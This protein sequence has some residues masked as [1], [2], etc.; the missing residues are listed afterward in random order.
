VPLLIGLCSAVQI[1]P[2]LLI[3]LVKRSWP[4]FQERNVSVLILG[5]V[6][7]FLT[8]TTSPAASNPVL[9]GIPLDAFAVQS[10]SQLWGHWLPFVAGYALW[11]TALLVRVRNLVIQHLRGGF[12][13]SGLLQML[14]AW[15]PWAA[16]SMLPVPVDLYA[17]IGLLVILGG[18]F[19]MLSLQL[20]PLRRDLDDLLPSM[21]LGICATAAL[22]TQSA[23]ILGGASYANPAGSVQVLFPA[24][25]SAFVGVHFC[26]T[27]SQLVWKLLRSTFHKFYLDLLPNLLDRLYGECSN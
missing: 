7:A 18:Y 27:V 26:M 2:C 23:L 14:V 4:P 17:H 8:A 11:F 9:Y 22:I 16:S 10:E 1:I 12:P 3:V 21:I 19:A 20:L 25:L 6:G 15:A 13:V 24:L 5:G